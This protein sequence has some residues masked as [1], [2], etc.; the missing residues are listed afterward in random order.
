MAANTSAV[1]PLSTTL[2]P[3]IT[4]MRSTF[5]AITP[6]SC[7]I[8]ISAMPRSATSSWMSRRIWR[9]TVASSAVVGSS[10][11]MSS[12]SAQSA[13]AMATRWRMPPEN[14][15]GYWAMRSR[16]CGISTS[17]SRA[18][19]RASASFSETGRCVRM[20]STRCRPTV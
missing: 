5:C 14:W 2:P 10:A 16:A 7:E 18:S 1:G 3:Y 9:C 17:S 11:M 13:R 12:G 20:V 19:A 8:R 6:R 4:S 15:C